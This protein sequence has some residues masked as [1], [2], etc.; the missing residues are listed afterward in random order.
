MEAAVA[1]IVSFFL[2]LVWWKSYGYV[3]RYGAYQKGRLRGFKEGLDLRD[4]I[5]AVVDEKG[6]ITGH[7]ALSNKKYIAFTSHEREP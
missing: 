7:V 2:G 6:D 4:P 5:H 3:E 1:C